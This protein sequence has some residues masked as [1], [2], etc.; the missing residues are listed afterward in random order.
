MPGTML[1]EV[2]VEKHA[3]HFEHLDIRD[4]EVEVCRVAENQTGTK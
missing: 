2:G 3:T 1:K 4:A